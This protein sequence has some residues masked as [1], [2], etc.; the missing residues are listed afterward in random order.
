MGV[1]VLFCRSVLS[2]YY[3]G[4][5]SYPSQDPPRMGF[6]STVPTDAD[7]KL[8]AAVTA[9]TKNGNGFPGK[10]YAFENP[11]PP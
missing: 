3:Y 1:E 7:D 5:L 10:Y 9:A 4:N 2:S 11:F 6:L 8:K